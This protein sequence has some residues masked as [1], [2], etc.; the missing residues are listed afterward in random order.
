MSKQD[1]EALRTR[2]TNTYPNYSYGMIDSLIKWKFLCNNSMYGGDC[3]GESYCND[4]CGHVD[5]I[6][7]CCNFKI[8]ACCSYHKSPFMER[9]LMCKQ[10]ED[11]SESNILVWK[12]IAN[13]FPLYG[14]DKI[15]ATAEQYS[16]QGDILHSQYGGCIGCDSVYFRCKQDCQHVDKKCQDCGLTVCGCCFNDCPICIS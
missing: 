15:H 10:P 3:Y 2:I 9:C 7:P 11:M 1:L 13:K 6:C 14:Y 16:L 4:N 12:I 8:C 5:Y